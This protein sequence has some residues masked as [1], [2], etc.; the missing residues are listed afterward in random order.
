MEQAA[1]ADPAAAP[2]ATE[3]A[4]IWL[5]FR[6]ML[7]PATGAA[8]PHLFFTSRQGHRLYLI[9][10]A[11]LTRYGRTFQAGRLYTIAG[12]GTAESKGAL[13]VPDDPN[14]PDVDETTYAYALGDG[15]PAYQAPLAF[16]QGVAEDSRHNLYVCDAGGYGVPLVNNDPAATIVAQQTNIYHQSIRLIRAADGKIFTFHL[17]KDG[18]AFPLSGAL[19]LR[20]AETAGGNWIYVSDSL[21]HCVV[22]FA[23]PADLADLDGAAP[24]VQPVEVVLGSYGTAGVRTADAAA[25]AVGAV[26]D[27]VPKAQVLLDTPTGLELD[28]AGNLVVADNGRVRL[29]DQAS[30]KVYTIA[31]SLPGGVDEGDARLVAPHPRYLTRQAGSGN[32]VVVDDPTGAVLKLWGDRGLR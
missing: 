8:M 20:V 14:T 28:A 12:F 24:A 10:G 6:L 13:L 30:G 1:V 19:D 25:P 23:L 9:P 2:L 29:L 32:M 7:E 21:H 18:A 26:N 22:R 4:P 3:G 16:P 11:D 27:G 15:G 5:P 17:T 31:G